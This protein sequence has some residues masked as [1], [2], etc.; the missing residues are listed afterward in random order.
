MRF[1]SKPTLFVILMTASAASVLLPMSWTNWVRAP[2]QITTLVQ[3]LFFDT[4]RAGADAVSGSS[5]AK[6]DEL[7]QALDRA[8]LQLSQQGQALA[9]LQR[10]LDDLTGLRSQM[11]DQHVKL[12]LAPIV[13]YD[14][15]PRRD[16]VLVILSADQ[17]NWVRPGQWVAAG[18]WETPSREALARQWLV[19][20]V[21]EVHTRSAR[22]QL[23]TDLKFRATVALGRI[24]SSNGG[25][26]NMSL[27]GELCRIEGL[28]AR[29]TGGGRMLITQAQ[30]NYFESGE[31]VVVAPTSR[32]LP[33]P[34][35]LGRLVSAAQDTRSAKHWDLAADPWMTL[36]GLTH[37]YIISVEP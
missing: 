8:R 36:R 26:A 2:F 1:P 28:G 14:A 33:F 4:A 19:G 24:E 11:P 21:S 35:V 16:T 9:N 10:I 31:T 27:V 32:E 29:A 22:I 18:A 34:M 20:K 25:P 7:Q 30:A 37:V 3:R 15:N 12:V 6:V 17:V 13:A 5:A 23:A